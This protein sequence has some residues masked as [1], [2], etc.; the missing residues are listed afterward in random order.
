PPF[1][2]FAASAAAVLAIFGAAAV[3]VR[4]FPWRYSPQA[5]RVASFMENADA[6]TEARYRVGTCF[7]TSRNPN[8]G[9]AAEQCLKSDPTK[10]NEL[11][12]GDRHA[13]QLWY[14]LSSV[15]RN[16]TFMQATAAGC[17][18]ALDQ[19]LGTDKRWYRLTHF[20]LRDDLA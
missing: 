4:G 5:V 13:A 1:S 12:V 16:T 2:P 10:R 9:F 14:G 6:V 19:P 7:L 17:K 18:P 8:A 20:V 15:F 3:F 11:I